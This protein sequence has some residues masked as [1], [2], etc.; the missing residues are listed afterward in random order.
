MRKALLLLILAAICV[1]VAL[2]FFRPDFSWST[3]AD[4]DEHGAVAEMDQPLPHTVLPSLAGEWVDLSAYKGQVVL[5]TFWSTWCSGCVDEVP[6]FIHLQ[7]EFAAKGFTVVAI[8]VGDNGEESVDSF[9]HKRQFNVH[10]DSVSINYPVL[11]GT[12][13]SAQK[14]GF[15]GGLPASILVSRDGHEVKIFRGLLSEP[16]FNRAIQR[17]LKN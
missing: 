5:L 8:A 7:Q 14:L 10:G 4:D 2:R 17:L 16:V 9:V 12:Q 15:E 1:A 3:D 6:S 13:E 11:M